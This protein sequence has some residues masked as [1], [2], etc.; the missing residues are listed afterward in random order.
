VDV[1]ER[2]GVIGLAV[3]AA[4]CVGCAV[5]TTTCPTGSKLI[6]SVRP[7]GRAQWCAAT[8]TVVAELPLSSRSFEG[9]LGIGH[10][11]AMP[12]GVEG[13]FTS[14]YPNGRLHSYGT[15]VSDGARSVPDGLWAFWHDNGQRWVIGKY[16]HGEPVGCFAQWDEDGHAATGVV[17][18]DQLHV[19]SC[20]PPRDDEVAVV[21]GRAQVKPESRA[22]GDVSVEGLMGPNHLGAA[23]PDQVSPDP[24]VTVAFTATARK[25]IG[26]LRVGPMFGLRWAD[27]GEGTGYTGA[28]SV[29][30][31]L[32]SF[33][34]RLDAEVSAELAIERLDVTALRRNLGTASLAFWSPLPAIQAGVAFEL[35]PGLA[36]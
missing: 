10:P 35:S 28:V 4:F 16:Q 20:T 29:G 27:S 36:A 1:I 8:D 33:H 26:R 25:R 15:Y 24:G 11:A 21:E 9:T 13:P 7:E 5:A 2:F 32:P 31:E 19:S 17:T 18:G 22:W 34:P 14:W 3:P 30:W 23:N 6:A 12:G